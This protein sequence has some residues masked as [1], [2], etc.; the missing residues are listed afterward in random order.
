MS[1]RNTKTGKYRGPSRPID[2]RRAPGRP[3]QRGPDR[4]GYVLVGIS[5]AFVLVLIVMIGIFQGAANGATTTTTGQAPAPNDPQAQAAATNAAA[6]AIEVAFATQITGLPTISPAD[7]RAQFAANSAKFIDVRD[8]AKYNASH[9]PGASNVVYT[10]AKNH[11]TEF[12]KAGNLILY[13]Q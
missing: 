5:V 11:M 1:N 7:A 9:I 2:P 8:T 10:D 6:T 12:P 4:F 3:Q 13:C